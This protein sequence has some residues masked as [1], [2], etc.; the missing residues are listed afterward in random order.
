[1]MIITWVCGHVL[2]YQIQHYLT[3]TYGYN[4]PFIVIVFLLAVYAHYRLFIHMTFKVLS[5]L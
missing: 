3:E 2:I 1:M 4:I 5:Y